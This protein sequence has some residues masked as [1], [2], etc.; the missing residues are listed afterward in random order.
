MQIRQLRLVYHDL[1][2][3][4]TRCSLVGIS[5]FCPIIASDDD[6]GRDRSSA[7]A[8]PLRACH[9]NVCL[10]ERFLG[11]WVIIV[12]HLLRPAAP[13]VWVA[14]SRMCIS[15]CVGDVC[16]RYS[17]EYDTNRYLT[18]HIPRSLG[19][20]KHIPVSCKIL[21]ENVIFT[22]SIFRKIR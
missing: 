1:S 16:A 21:R 15:R 14:Q 2:V 9:L 8:N 5:I 4:H 6:R 18:L 22:P 3:W 11:N 20:K 10:F 17:V 7:I 19:K 12:G 13:G